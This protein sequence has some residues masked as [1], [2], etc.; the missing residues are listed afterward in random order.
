MKLEEGERIED[1]QCKGLK[2]IQNRNYYTFTS[3]SVIL[4]NFIRLYPKDVCGEIGTGCG[5]IPLLLSAKNSFKKIYAF[6]LQEE[7]AKLAKKN[8]KLNELEEKIEVICDNINNFTKYLPKNSLDCVFSN[9]PYMLEGGKNQNQIRNIARH[10]NTLKL[11][12]LCEIS[13]QLLKEGGRL[14]LVYTAERSVQL[15]YNLTKN[16]LEIKRMFFT[17]NGKGK[18]KLIV[19][20]AVKGGRAGVRVLPEL[21]T[22][23][24]NGDY[25]K[26]LHTK[27]FNEDIK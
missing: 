14:Y 10:E 15:I 26:T 8:V 13:S 2:I 1:L 16:S 6:E 27:Y 18:V 11:E 17:Q 19:L 4:A 21:V 23:E 25:L 5:V 22:N 7:M 20:E 24:E 3:D 9:P 12:K